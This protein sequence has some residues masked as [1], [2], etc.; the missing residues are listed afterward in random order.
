[1]S[2]QEIERKYLVMQPPDGLDAYPH[3]TIIQG[4]IAI[5]P[6]GTEVRLRQKGD[7]YFQTIK[8]KGE[9]IRMEL[10]IELTSAQFEA[11]WPATEERR[12]EKIRYDVAYGPYTIEL[13]IYQG[14]LTGLYTA[15][16]EFDTLEACEAFVPPPW[17]GC[18]LTADARYKNRNLAL[19]GLPT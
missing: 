19:S 6:E 1:M 10:E 11:L 3:A 8:S 9:R 2:T 4:Y 13:D 16:V 12:V 18:E 14:R 17:F 15:E 7:R 5:P